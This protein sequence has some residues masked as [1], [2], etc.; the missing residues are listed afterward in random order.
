MIDVHVG[1]VIVDLRWTYTEFYSRYSILMTQT[2]LLVNEKKQT[3][4]TVLQR[5]IPVRSC[6]PPL[7]SLLLSPFPLLSYPPLPLLSSPFLS[8]SLLLFCLIV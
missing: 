3:C 7:S 5:L 8:S 2:E 1:F 4:K 6:S